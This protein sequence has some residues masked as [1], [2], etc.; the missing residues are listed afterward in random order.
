M[1]QV[2][3]HDLTGEALETADAFQCWSI[4][5]SA[6]VLGCRLLIRAWTG[7]RRDFGR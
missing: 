7:Q 4:A 2:A 1:R 3:V 5:Q 6:H